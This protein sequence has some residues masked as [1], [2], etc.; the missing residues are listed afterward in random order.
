MNRSIHKAVGVHCSPFVRIGGHVT[1]PPP[2]LAIVQTDGSYRFKEGSIA[3]ILTMSHRLTSCS[4][5]KKLFAAQSSTETEWAAIAHGL[6]MALNRGE[7]AI[8]IENDNLGVV[9]T[10]ILNKDPKQKYAKYYKDI[11]LT[12]TKHSVWTGIRWIPREMNK[13]DGLL[14]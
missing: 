3:A 4:Q 11:I 13:A 8:G 10:L 2:L 12:L 9:G 14:R 1:F 6:E 5:T 7:E